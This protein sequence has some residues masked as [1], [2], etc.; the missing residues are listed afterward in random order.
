[1]FRSGLCRGHII[2]PGTSCS[3]LC[4]RQ[5]L[6][7]LTWGQSYTSLMV[8][9][10][11]QVSACISQHREHINPEQ[12]SNF[13]CMNAVPDLQR[14]STRLHC[15]LQI[16]TIVPLS[17]PSVNKVPSATVK[18]CQILTHESGIPAVIF[19][20]PVPMFS[21]IS[22]KLLGLVFMSEGWLFGCNSSM[23]TTSVQ[24]S[25]DSACVYLLLTAF[26]TEPMA[27][28]DVFWFQRKISSVCTKFPWPMIACTILDVAVSLCFFKRAHLETPVCFETFV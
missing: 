12:I 16:L 2:T 5:S 3:S 7:T 18:I 6:E 8:L 13:I 1:M 10:D 20:H 22:V 25:P 15:C 4:K 17:S 21:C 26:S 23:K 24:T 14:H 28:L 27:L 11:V 19:L 9:H